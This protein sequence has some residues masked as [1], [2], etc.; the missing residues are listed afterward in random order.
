MEIMLEG[1][2]KPTGYILQVSILI[3]VIN[4]EPY[5]NIGYGY[6]IYPK[7]QGSE[8]CLGP[9]KLRGLAL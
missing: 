2:S 3:V 6:R 4:F 9:N 5:S 1:S 7:K 8:K